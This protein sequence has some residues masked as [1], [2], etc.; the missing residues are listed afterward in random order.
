[1]MVSELVEGPA[2]A[3]R[4][5]VYEGVMLATASDKRCAN[6]LLYV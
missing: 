6:G 5:D 1:M 4:T 2:F 3:L